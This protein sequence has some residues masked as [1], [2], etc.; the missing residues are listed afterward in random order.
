[1]TTQS[2]FFGDAPWRALAACKGKPT[3]WWFDGTNEE[4][5]RAQSICARCPVREP[6]A[7][8]GR[9]QHQGRWGGVDMEVERRRMRHRR[10]SA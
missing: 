10:L 2:W 6:C 3:R 8:F 9:S 5:D 7:E 1:M 4:R